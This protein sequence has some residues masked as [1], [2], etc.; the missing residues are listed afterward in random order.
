[1][2]ETFYKGK[3]QI[4]FIVIDSVDCPIACLTE[5]SFSESVEMLDTTT[6]DNEGWKTSR[7]LNQ[8]Y[9]IDFSGIQIITDETT[10]T[11]YS[12]N[13][14]VGL[15]RDRVKIKWKTLIDTSTIYHEQHGSGYITNLSEAAAVGDF[16]TFDGTIEGYGKPTLIST[17]G[18]ENNRVFED[19]NNKVFEDGN[20][21]IIFE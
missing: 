13:L 20:N 11:K 16:L 9:S 19:G 15:K 14:L 12:Y 1:M 21:H 7:P 8:N 10:I 17:V 3:E 6:V 18:T 4:L 5:N 2:A